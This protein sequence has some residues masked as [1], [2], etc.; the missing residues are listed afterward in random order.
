MLFSHSDVVSLTLSRYLPNS[1][2]TAPYNERYH[3]CNTWWSLPPHLMCGGARVLHHAEGGAA[4]PRPD[5]I[6]PCGMCHVHWQL[7]ETASK[8]KTECSWPIPEK[9]LTP[10]HH[11]ITQGRVLW[12][13]RCPLTQIPCIYHMR[14]LKAH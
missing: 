11:N 5:I 6:V 12:I 10:Q 2:P 3:F 14:S 13:A 9:V 7:G 4:A 8:V 1:H